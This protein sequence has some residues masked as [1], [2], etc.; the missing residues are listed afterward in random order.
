MTENISTNIHAVR[1]L[2]ND[3]HRQELQGFNYWNDK[4]FIFLYV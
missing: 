4:T 1:S 3:R 2:I